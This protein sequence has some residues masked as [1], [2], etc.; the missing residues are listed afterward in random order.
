[1]THITE[2]SA[3][4][5]PAQFQ[6]P[7]VTSTEGIEGKDKHD[8]DNLD[9]S[10]IKVEKNASTCAA[11]ASEETKAYV[12]VEAVSDSAPKNVDDEETITVKG[13][14]KARVGAKAK[15][16]ADRESQ[17]HGY[18]TRL[19]EKLRAAAKNGASSS[20]NETAAA[21]GSARVVENKSPIT[22]SSATARQSEHAMEERP[23]ALSPRTPL[24]LAQGNVVPA[25]PKTP[26]TPTIATSPVK[27]NEDTSQ[28]YEHKPLKR[29]G[30]FYEHYSGSRGQKRRWEE[31]ETDVETEVETDKEQTPC[32]AAK[33][34]R[35][36]KILDNE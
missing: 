30:A 9:K 19:A 21:I 8:Q 31:V 12:D 26:K 2:P 28:P 27:E 6:A 16:T 36:V 18:P 25:S 5:V 11:D 23:V 29:E 10:E 20:D 3:S 32:R 7:S 15:T 4:V 35:T 17:A 14:G 13:K 1:M 33:R 22:Q 24:R 34:C